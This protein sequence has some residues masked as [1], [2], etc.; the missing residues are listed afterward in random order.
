VEIESCG[1]FVQAKLEWKI[2]G[3]G[4][5]WHGQVKVAVGNLRYFSSLATA[6]A[7]VKK[8]NILNFETCYF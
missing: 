1:A 5:C 7:A 4:Q 2:Y 3:D 8:C 6:C